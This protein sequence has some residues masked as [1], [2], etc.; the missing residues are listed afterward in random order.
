MSAWTGRY[1]HFGITTTSRVEAAHRYVK[2]YIASGSCDLI[3]AFERISDSLQAQLNSVKYEHSRDAIETLTV[4]DQSIFD[5]RNVERKISRHA[6]RLA[7]KG[8]DKQTAIQLG[9]PSLQLRL[10][11][12]SEPLQVSDFHWQWRI[13]SQ[14]TAPMLREPLPMAAFRANQWSTG[15]SRT[16]QRI[17]SQF[18]IIERQLEKQ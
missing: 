5:F 16:M 11:R 14:L 13:Y 12:P 8:L 2:S 4:T 17:P 3:T 18:E 6:L 10:N 1:T 7:L 9:V 15:N